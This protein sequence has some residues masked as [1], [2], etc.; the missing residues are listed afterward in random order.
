MEREQQDLYII[1][2]WDYVGVY[3]MKKNVSYTP[4]ERNL[5]IFYLPWANEKG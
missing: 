4:G 3:A 5:E 2:L 1:T